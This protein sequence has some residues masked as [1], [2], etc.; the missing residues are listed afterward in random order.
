MQVSHLKFEVLKETPKGV[1]IDYCF[2]KRFILNKCKKQFAS[3]TVEIAIEKFKKRNARYQQ[4]L[5]AR[6]KS[7]EEAL[8]YVENYH[9]ES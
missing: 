2:D 7:A 5:R 1:W 8:L 4:I 3:P 9:F 6:L